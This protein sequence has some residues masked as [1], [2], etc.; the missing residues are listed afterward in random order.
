MFAVARSLNTTVLCAHHMSK[1]AAGR[2][3][4]PGDMFGSAYFRNGA[5]NAWEMRAAQEGTRLRVALFHRKANDDI[6]ET[7]PVGWEYRWDRPTNT[8]T[9]STIEDHDRSANSD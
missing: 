3:T 7:E 4:A 1:E 8:T 6:L 5:R 2:E 9:T